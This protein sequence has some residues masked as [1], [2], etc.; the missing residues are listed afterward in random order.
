MLQQRL[1]RG[2]VG[3]IA[4]K[5]KGQFWPRRGLD[6]GRHPLLADVGE[7]GPHALTDQSLRDGA[8]D[9]VTGAGHQR[10]LVRGVEGWAQQAHGVVSRGGR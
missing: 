7:H 8:A 4:D 10:R 2:G 5:G 6:R 3:E 9:A 1:T